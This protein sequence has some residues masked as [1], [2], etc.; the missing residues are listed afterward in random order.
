VNII[1]AA[2]PLPCVKTVLGITQLLRIPDGGYKNDIFFQ[3]SFMAIIKERFSIMQH[4][5]IQL[6]RQTFYIIMY[7]TEISA[8]GNAIKR[9]T[10]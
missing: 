3:L 8:I 1:F 5:F 6:E 10:K 2:P 7:L 9:E 4:F